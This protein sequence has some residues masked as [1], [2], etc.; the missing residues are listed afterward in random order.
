MG[1]TPRAGAIAWITA[2]CPIPGPCV[3]S[4]R[5]ATREVRGAISISRSSHLLARLY[6]NCVKPVTL[7]PGL[8]MLST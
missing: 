4:R 5:T 3:G 8:A 1:S 6:S 7:P 2:N